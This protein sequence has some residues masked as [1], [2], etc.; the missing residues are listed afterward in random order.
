MNFGKVFCEECR[1]D[2]RYIVKGVILEGTIR[3]EAYSYEGKAA[4]CKQCGAKIYTAEINDYN[5]EA[6]Y[7]AFREKHYIISHRKIREIPEKYGIGKRP[8]SLLLGWGELTFTRYYEGDIPTRQYADVLQKIYE[9]PQYYIEMLEQN[10][11][12]LP[13]YQG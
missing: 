13:W 4:Y 12:Y 11:D 3:G 6:L 1:D 10:K 5:L 9:S 2:V 7:D 8:L